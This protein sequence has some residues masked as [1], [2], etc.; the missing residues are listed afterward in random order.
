MYKFF[1]ENQVLVVELA[2]LQELLLDERKPFHF[3]KDQWYNRFS[4]KDDA[5]T[6]CTPAE[7][8]AMHTVLMQVRAEMAAIRNNISNA[9]AREEV[10]L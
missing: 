6:E 3:T 9:H 8:I 1:E 5:R 10:A 4:I 2:R 7:R